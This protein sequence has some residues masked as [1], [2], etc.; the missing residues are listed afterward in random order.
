MNKEK[1][2]MTSF[3]AANMADVVLTKIAT[4]HFNAAEFGVLGSQMTEI[5][6]GNELV[7]ASKI[8]ITT[9]IIG[10]Y[11]LTQKEGKRWK[12]STDKVL[13]IGNVMVWGVVTWDAANLAAEVASKL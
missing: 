13:K 7:Y 10:L 11:A 4:E 9:I 8:A 5:P 2:L 1:A 12:F 3:L 6:N